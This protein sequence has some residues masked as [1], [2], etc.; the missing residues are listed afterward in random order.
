[1][2]PNPVEAV[3]GTRS[4]A[5]SSTHGATY[6]FSA[7]DVRVDLSAHHPHSWTEAQL[8]LLLA[9]LMHN[10]RVTSLRLCGFAFGGRR[11]LACRA[12]KAALGRNVC[13]ERLELVGCSF[14]ADALGEWSAAIEANDKL[15]LKGLSLVGVGGE[16]P[17]HCRATGQLLSRLLRSMHAPLLELTLDGCGVTSM[18]L[19]QV[20]EALHR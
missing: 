3:D 2:E 6:D 18:P 14:D 1:M 8:A 7:M 16:L 9:C 5:A 12:L 15:P 4:T 19:R 17:R 13:L 10:A 20:L 11:T